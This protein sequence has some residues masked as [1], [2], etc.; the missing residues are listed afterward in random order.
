MKQE[1][2]RKNKH[3]AEMKLNETVR[4]DSMLASA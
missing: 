4:R 2:N 3:N 1:L